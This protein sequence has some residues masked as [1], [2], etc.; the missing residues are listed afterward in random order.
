MELCAVQQ[1]RSLFVISQGKYF[2]IAVLLVFPVQLH[3]HLPLCV[4]GLSGIASRGCL[5]QRA[6]FWLAHDGKKSERIKRAKSW[7]ERSLS[8]SETSSWRASLFWWC[9][10]QMSRRVQSSNVCKGVLAGK[11]MGGGGY[12]LNQLP[13]EYNKW[14]YNPQISNSNSKLQWLDIVSILLVPMLLTVSPWSLYQVRTWLFS[15]HIITLMP[16]ISSVFLECLFKAEH[17]HSLKWMADPIQPSHNTKPVM[18]SSHISVVSNEMGQL[19]KV[20]FTHCLSLLM[21]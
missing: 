9:C 15:G 17:L 14:S 21:E 5:E 16:D 13:T 8:R 4:V 2:F 10:I 3:G 1:C 6:S 12:S 11:R 20:L 19:L 7:Y 18:T